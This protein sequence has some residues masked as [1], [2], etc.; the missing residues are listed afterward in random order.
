M[1]TVKAL[2]LDQG[3]SAALMAIDWCNELLQTYGD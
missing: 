3:E 1:D 2:L